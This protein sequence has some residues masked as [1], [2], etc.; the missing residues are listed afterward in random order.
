VKVGQLIQK[1]QE[2]SPD[3]EVGI[4]NDD[5]DWA[6]DLG[7]VYLDSRMV[8]I[9]TPNPVEEHLVVLASGSE[10]L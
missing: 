8:G 9:A 7:E 3:A 10:G 6:R 4:L 1:L 5:G 2:F